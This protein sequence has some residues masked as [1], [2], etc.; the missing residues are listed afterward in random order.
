MTTKIEKGSEIYEI[1]TYDHSHKSYVRKMVV[2]SFGKKQGTAVSSVNG[3]QVEFRLY[4][5]DEGITLFHVND[6]ADVA[7]FAL[8]KAVAHKKAVTAHYAL[9]S[10]LEQDA[11][12]LYHKNITA[13]ARVQIE[14]TPEV[15][16]YAK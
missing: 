10:Y 8:E 9:R 11:S 6:I 16:F 15:F 12:D 14:Q 7:A 13:L 1:G 5:K 3:K 4:A 2:T